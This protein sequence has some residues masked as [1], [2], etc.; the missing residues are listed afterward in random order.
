MCTLFKKVA[1]FHCDFMINKS[2]W[3]I[4]KIVSYKKNRKEEPTDLHLSFFF[5]SF[6]SR[7]SALNRNFFFLLYTEWY[8]FYSKGH[9]SFLQVQ[10][11][12]KLFVKDM[13]IDN[14]W[15]TNSYQSSIISRIFLLLLNYFPAL[16]YLK[17]Q[18]MPVILYSA[19]WVTIRQNSKNKISISAYNLDD[20]S[21]IKCFVL[22]HANIS[23]EKIIEVS[24]LYHRLL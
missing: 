5:S 2:Q 3:I 10:L 24:F 4:E 8:F 7:Y 14:S 16:R 1:L 17:R 20:K 23:K 15:H 11:S 12:T 9:T 18:T 13:S 21:C 19:L 6:S 22:S